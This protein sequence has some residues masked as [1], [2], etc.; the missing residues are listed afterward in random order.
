MDEFWVLCYDGP[1]GTVFDLRVS[2]EHLLRAGGAVA[3]VV[4]Q[5]TVAKSDLKLPKQ[6]ER[7]GSRLNAIC[8]PLLLRLRYY[9]SYPYVAGMISSS[10]AWFAPSS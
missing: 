10:I 9:S 6:H 7:L 2:E 3:S 8:Y 5:Y 1:I 4:S